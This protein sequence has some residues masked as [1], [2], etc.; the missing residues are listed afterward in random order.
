MR[1]ASG[2]PGRPLFLF[3]RRRVRGPVEMERQDPMRAK[4]P[5]EARLLARIEP[6]AAEAGFEIVRLR[7]QGGDKGRRL[8]IMAERGDGTMGVEDCAALSRQLSAL[9]DVE[10]PFTGAWALEVSSPGVDRPLT[11]LEHFPRW[12]GFEARLELDRLVEG[13]KRFAGVIAGI[14]PDE[15]EGGDESHPPEGRVAGGAV[16][17]DLPGEEETAVFPFA[18]IVEARLVMT[19]ALIAESLRR[20]AAQPAPAD[21]ETMEALSVDD[22]PADET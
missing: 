17:L 16:L 22:A 11:R 14:E 9:L 7:V 8:Q 21:D 18:W 19:D 13:R 10:D 20:G 15:A 4:T 2:S 1:Q 5:L 3:P 6:S 12:E